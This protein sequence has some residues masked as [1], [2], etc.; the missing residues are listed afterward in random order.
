MIERVDTKTTETET[1]IVGTGADLMLEINGRLTEEQLQQKEIDLPTL[2]TQWHIERFSV[3]QG[4]T[5]G[6]IATRYFPQLNI[7]YIPLMD[8]EDHQTGTI[9]IGPAT[10]DLHWKQL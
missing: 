9:M 5:I 8:G 6:G 7:V 4:R 2:D 10:E 1:L 3:E